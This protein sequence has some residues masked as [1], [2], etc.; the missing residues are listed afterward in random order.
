[1]NSGKGLVFRSENVLQSLI[2]GPAARKNDQTEVSDAEIAYYGSNTCPQFDAETP[3]RV[4]GAE[5]DDI[6][7]F[8]DE[9]VVQNGPVVNAV[10]RTGLFDDN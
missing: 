9:F 1:M 10:H 7:D 3:S 6:D 8:P 5:R 2:S 4:T